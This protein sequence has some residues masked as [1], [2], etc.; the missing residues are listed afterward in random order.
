MFQVANNGT[1]GHFR[2]GEHVAHNQLRLLAAVHELHN[3][4]P[5]HMSALE[6]VHVL[7]PKGER[8]EESSERSMR[9]KGTREEKV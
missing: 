1:L 6:I 4:K 7:L 2:D 8:R 9:K 5:R 3:N